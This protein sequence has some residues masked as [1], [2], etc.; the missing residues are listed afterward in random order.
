[1]KLHIFL[2]ASNLEWSDLCLSE[3]IRG[4]VP[5]LLLYS[6][7]AALPLPPT[8]VNSYRL[9]MAE[10]ITTFFFFFPFVFNLRPKIVVHYT[11]SYLPQPDRAN[12]NSRSVDRLFWTAYISS[13]VGFPDSRM[14]KCSFGR[15][16]KEPLGAAA[17]VGSKCLP[18]RHQSLCHGKNPTGPFTILNPQNQKSDY[19]FQKRRATDFEG[20]KCPS[21]SQLLLS[22]IRKRRDEILLLARVDWDEMS[23]Y[24]PA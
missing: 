2:K 19:V 4:L 11:L 8:H 10:M 15:R 22:R 1:M 13:I 23:I 6:E 20:L 14:A 7:R 18:L 12:R 5:I 16:L 9:C 3:R 17:N 21:G 24:P